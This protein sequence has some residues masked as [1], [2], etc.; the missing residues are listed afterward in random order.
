MCAARA[1]EIYERDAE[2]RMKA[3]TKADPVENLPQGKARDIAGKAFGVSGKSVDH[4]KRVLDKGIPELAKAVDEGRMA[5]SDGRMR[6]GYV[7]ITIAYECCELDSVRPHKCEA[8][9]VLM[10]RRTTMAS[11]NDDKGDLSKCTEAALT[12]HYSSCE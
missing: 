2:S 4:A 9:N 7:Q 3:G 10:S 8:L 5:V 12:W 6:P 1:R 11:G